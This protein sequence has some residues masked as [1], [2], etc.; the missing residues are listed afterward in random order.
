VSGLVRTERRGRVLLV[1]MQREQKRNAVDRELADAIDAAL[2]ELDDDPDLWVSVLTGT[3]AVFSAGSDL[4]SRGDYVTDRGGEYGV[5]RRVRRKPLIA[6]VEGLALGG[7]F[8]IVL[9]CDLVV[10]ARSARFGLP[11]VSRGLVPTCGALFRGP[12]ALPLNLAREMILTGATVDAT[13]LHAAGVVNVL[14]DP[15]GAVDAA[16]ELAEQIC[17]NAPLAVQACLTAVNGLAAR[18]DVDGWA[19]TTE[20]MDAIAGSHDQQE[21]VRAFFERRDP[22]WTG[23]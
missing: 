3:D 8:E 20:A 10:A 16:I 21:G 12:T 7:G 15:G 9:A 13:R 4:A 14:T 23:R 5:I 18:S 2:N 6:A 11:E 17:R 22:E 19:A 1:S